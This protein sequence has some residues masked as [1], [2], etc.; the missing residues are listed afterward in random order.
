MIKK[1]LMAGGVV[2][3]VAA[4]V[5]AVSLGIDD[6]ANDWHRQYY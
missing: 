3:L 2:L 1:L 6:G 4:A 5:M